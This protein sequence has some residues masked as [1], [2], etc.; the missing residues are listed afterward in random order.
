V[1]PSS[2]EIFGM[3]KAF[4][5]PNDY[6]RGAD[7]LIRAINLVALANAQEIELSR[8]VERH[9]RRRRERWRAPRMSE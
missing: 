9:Y 7:E 3:E 1:R 5:W 2:V 6:L 4:S 8:I